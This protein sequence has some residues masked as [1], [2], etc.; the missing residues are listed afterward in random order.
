M[1]QE[2][3][4]L[5][6]MLQ[7]FKRTNKVKDLKGVFCNVKNRKCNVG[8]SLE[9]LPQNGDSLLREIDRGTLGHVSFLN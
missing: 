4:I 1:L 5:F 7:D 6:H 8:L 3:Q 9:S 2:L